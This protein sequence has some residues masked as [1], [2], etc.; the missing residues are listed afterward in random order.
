MPRTSLVGAVARGI[1]LVLACAPRCLRAPRQIQDHATRQGNQTEKAHQRNAAGRVRQ[2]CVAV[3][4]V[5][6]IILRGSLGNAVIGHRLGL[7]LRRIILR[8]DEA[9]RRVCLRGRLRYRHLTLIDALLALY[10]LRLSG[11]LLGYLLG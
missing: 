6:G 8:N 3:V 5:R 7:G 1:A 4:I 11:R 2:G 10:R 9:V